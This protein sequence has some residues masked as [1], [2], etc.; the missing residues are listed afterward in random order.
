MARFG[1]MNARVLR[2]SIDGLVKSSSIAVLL[3]FA[4]IVHSDDV[5]DSEDAKFEIWLEAVRVEAREKGISQ[6]TIKTALSDVKLIKRVIKRDKNQPEV[7][8][9]YASYLKARVSEWRINN[10]RKRITDHSALFSEIAEQYGVQPRFIAAIWG[11]ETNYG[12]YELT[13]PVFDAIATLA[14]YPRRAARFRRELFASLK[15]IESGEATM[16]MM[17]GSWAGA[18]GQPQFMPENFIVYAK[19]HDGDGLRDIWNTEA[20]VF[21]SIASYLKHYGWNDSQTWGRKVQLPKGREI[22]INNDKTAGVSPDK[23]C[24]RFKSM[25]TWR[26]LSEWQALGVRRLNGDA[27]PARNLPAA[28]I[29][30]DEGDDQGYLVYRNFCSVMKYNPSF[31]YALGVSM[32][33]DKIKGGVQ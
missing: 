9:T 27:L 33:A 28:L 5:K 22:A 20:D 21:A 17:M 1:S 8:Q 18:M 30:G 23:A 19:D 25:G 10:G 2:N 11:I 3:L 12:T 31:K 14:F 29:V 7:K 13:I 32:L 6:E 26:L 16:D 24:K 15:I 4:P